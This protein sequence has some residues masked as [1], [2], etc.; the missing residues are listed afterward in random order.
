MANL[1]G[2]SARRPQRACQY[3]A[4]HLLARILMS[5]GDRQRGWRAETLFSD[6]C[7]RDG[8]AYFY[9]ERPML[10]V[11]TSRRGHQASRRAMGIPIIGL[12]VMGTCRCRLLRMWALACEQ[13][14]SLVCIWPG[15]FPF[16]LEG[17]DGEA[18]VG[19][20]I[21]MMQNTGSAHVCKLCEAFELRIRC[22]TCSW[23]LGITNSV[24]KP[25]ATRA[26]PSEASGC[27]ISSLVQP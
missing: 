10:T 4:S 16:S 20:I 19:C 11:P 6:R 22:C 14:Q 25:P 7:G 23:Q 26:L 21:S 12:I 18:D 24:S 5:A 9:L 3:P 1:T 13:L 2:V 27:A 17:P 15:P 8:S